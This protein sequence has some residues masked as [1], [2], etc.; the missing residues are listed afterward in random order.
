MLF[1]VVVAQSQHMVRHLENFLGDIDMKLNSKIL[2]LTA[3][4]GLGLIFTNA[5]IAGTCTS[6]S[7]IGSPDFADMTVSTSCLNDVYNTALDPGNGGNVTA[8][9]MNSYGS[10]GAFDLNNWEAAGKIDNV[11]TSIFDF[12]TIGATSGTWELKPGQ[13]F[14]AG[15]AYAFVL[16]GAQ[17]SA[18]YLMDTAFGKGDWNTNGLLNRG[19]Q[20]PALSNVAIFKAQTPVPLPAAAYLFGSALLGMAGIGYRRN[21]KQA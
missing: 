2:G 3:L 17:D 9:M 4:A 16:K 12:F 20:H 1:S 11:N 19:G 13:S 8:E 5:S 7:T 10:A 21:K 14:E 15:Y 6:G 18:V